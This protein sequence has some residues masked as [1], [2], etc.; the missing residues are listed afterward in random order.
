MT[1]Q[2]TT[3]EMSKPSESETTLL[4]SEVRDYLQSSLDSL[5]ESSSG[6]SVFYLYPGST[7]GSPVTYL[8]LSPEEGAGRVSLFFAVSV[9]QK[10]EYKFLKFVSDTYQIDLNLPTNQVAAS[11]LGDNGFL[12]VGSIIISYEKLALLDFMTSID[13]PAFLEVTLSSGVVLIPIE[14]PMKKGFQAVLMAQKALEMGLV[15]RN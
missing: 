1:N 12:Y 15:R 8:T 14:P 5:V 13:E 6:S 7:F 3:S 2:F 11:D 4:D 10:S 9:E